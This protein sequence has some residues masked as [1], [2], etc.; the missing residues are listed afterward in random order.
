MD[1]PGLETL[2]AKHMITRPLLIALKRVLPH[3]QRT[4]LDIYYVFFSLSAQIALAFL[5]PLFYSLG[6]TRIAVAC[7]TSL[8][9]ITFAFV[10]WL[11][12]LP[13]LW[14]QSI[15]QAAM[16]GIIFYV[17]CI[18]GGMR[19]SAIVWLVIVP[20][21]P[22][23]SS[24]SRKV[25]GFWLGVSLA[26][27]MSLL[28]LQLTGTIE[29][30]SPQS[31]GLLIKDAVIYVILIYAQWS[32]IDA[33]DSMN[34]TSL[35]NTTRA[36]IS[37]KRLSQDLQ[38]A[39]A[40][41]DQFLAIVSHEMRTPLNAVMGYLSL[42]STDERI[43]RDVKEFVTGAQNSAAHLLTVINDLL[44]FSQ[45]QNGKI[46]MNPQ[47][48]NLHTMLRTTHSTL[49]PR[50]I[51]LGLD[52]HLHLDPNVPEWICA[53]QHRLTQVLVNLLGN[54][55][56]FTDKGHV[57][58]RVA[59]SPSTHKPSTGKLFVHVEDTGLGIPADAQARIFEPF[60]QLARTQPAASR[61]D[62][63]RGNGL[64]LSISDTL[65]KSHGG[66]LT[67]HSVEGQGS[68]FSFQLP[69][70][71]APAPQKTTPVLESVDTT[72]LTLLI[73][74]DHAVNRL[75]AKTT[76][77]RAL[78][79]ARIEEAENGTTGLA[80][81]SANRYDLVLLDLV[82]PDIDGIEVMRRVRTTLPEPFNQVPVI[83][84][85]ANVA[86]DALKACKEVGFD[87]V[88]PKPFDRH[89]LINRVLHYSIRSNNLLEP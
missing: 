12:G 60:V 57:K 45:I 40:H 6:E 78:P 74:D 88:M 75:V 30:H 56:K 62:A 79:N 81:M 89:T 20:I 72:P 53:D 4:T 83:A 17:A 33:I 3:K 35:R 18:D 7:L 77:Q 71:L 63:L 32:L 28:A 9:C 80:K 10:L 58:M 55:L 47:V 51:E 61:R 1:P 70:Q 48:F 19:S 73:V 65:I 43:T 25:V 8:S 41:K 21:L 76:I 52:Y 54:A 29:L 24:N 5:V 64:G 67:L 26:C 16:M 23:F 66:E 86:S 36:N 13:R 84:L 15:D 85:T 46:T 27:V 38:Q 49:S 39:N 14:A 37:L 50:A 69:V 87:E 11:K 2:E 42:M 68:T 31:S 22:L 34:V 44:D 59:F 82:M